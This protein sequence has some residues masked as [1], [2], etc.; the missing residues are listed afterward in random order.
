MNRDADG[1]LY[2]KTA[3][4]LIE[5]TDRML[6]QIAAA[7]IAAINGTGSRQA[8]EAKLKELNDVI[9]ETL[10]LSSRY[11]LAVSRAYAANSRAIGF[12]FQ[13][14]FI[15]VIVVLAIAVLLLGLFTF[16]LANS[17]TRP[18]TSIIS[19]IRSLGEGDISSLKKIE[20]TSKDEIGVLTSEFN[21]L[22]DSISSLNSFKK[23]IEEDD[24]IEDV[25]IRLAQKFK[26]DF[27]LQ[28]V[29]IYEIANSQN[30]MRA[31]YPLEMSVASLACNPDVLNDCHLCRAKKTGHEVSSFAHP[32]MCR[33]F[34][35][36]N[37]RDYVCIPLIMGGVT[38]GVVQ[39]LFKPDNGADRKAIGHKLFM[40]RQYITESVS[41]IDAKRL[42]TTLKDSALKDS[43][44][45]LYNRRFLQEYTESLVA[46]V[47]RREKQVGLIMCDLDYFKQI[48]DLYGHNTGDAVLKETSVHIRN[49][50][51]SS[52]LVIRFGGEEFLVVLL[53]IK[54][55]E[56]EAVAEKIRASIE[57]AKLKVPD[58]VI[59]KTISL[60][61]SEFPS[62]TDSF[63]HAIKYADVALYKAKEGGRNKALRFVPEMWK[64]EQF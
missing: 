34:L 25:Y 20:I 2:L 40:A 61:I 6:D 38:G 5:S 28:E 55:G 58:G 11:S 46:G 31:V 47:L 30:K 24:A 57:T 33:S 48:N 52:D 15:T 37:D 9:T 3:G 44:T 27:G 63:W 35:A 45:G 32:E 12:D 42:M 22:M 39:F 64:D 1:E 26:N 16:W 4:P 43:L 62:D 23:L 41:V 8:V 18:I 7:R 51:R 59:K 49:S 21:G 56:S 17:F 14:T 53:D 13:C 60:G 50:V 19:Q 10:A 29:T 54:P 36:G